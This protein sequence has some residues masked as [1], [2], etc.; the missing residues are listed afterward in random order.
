VTYEDPHYCT[1]CDYVIGVYGYHNSTYTLMVTDQEDAIIKLVQN[2]PQIAAIGKKD[3]TLYFSAVISSSASDMTV[4]LTSLG[5]GFADLYV[6]VYNA[7]TFYSPAGGDVYRLPDPNV[8]SSYKYTTAGTED[9]HVY[10]KGPHWQETIVVILV[11][12]TV[13]WF[14]S[15]ITAVSYL[16]LNMSSGERSALQHR[17]DVLSESRAAAGWRA[18]EPLRPVRQHGVLQVLPAR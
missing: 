1:D 9:D 18:P 2:R 16:L 8:P 6:A 5:T 10:I 13:L 17:G 4:T 7:S 15:H 3:G 12:G 14:L 11:K